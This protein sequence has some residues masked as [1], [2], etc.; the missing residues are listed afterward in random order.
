MPICFVYRLHW[1]IER[2]VLEEGREVAYTE[3]LAATGTLECV[4]ALSE[5]DKC[6]GLVDDSSSF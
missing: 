1:G 4:S 3:I 2:G 5:K 6:M